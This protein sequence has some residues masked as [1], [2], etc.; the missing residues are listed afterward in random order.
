MDLEHQT[1]SV[2]T[3]SEPMRAAQVGTSAIIARPA[4]GEFM[5]MQRLAEA[6][7]QV[8]MYPRCDDERE[9]AEAVAWAKFPPV[10]RRGCDSA[11]PDALYLAMSLAEYVQAANE[12][13][14]LIVQVETP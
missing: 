14:F 7:D 8:I 12:Q 2:A 4:K 9:A 5:R 10:G 11:N 6:V 13:T 3:A 1:S